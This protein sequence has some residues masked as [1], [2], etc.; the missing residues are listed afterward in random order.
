MWISIITL[1]P[2]MFQALQVGVIGKAIK[3]NRLILSCVNPRDFTTDARHSVDDRPYG[4]GTGMIMMVEPLY[5]ALQA[6]KNAAPTTPTTIYLSPQ[7]QLFNQATALQFKETTS[8]IFIAGRYEGIDERLIEQEVD[9]EW[10]IG[11]YILT[12]GELAAMVMVDAT[13]RLLPGVVGDPASIT[14]DSITTGLLKYPQYTRPE[15]ALNLP[16]PD[17]LLSGN[18]A[19]IQTWRL[20]QS[21]SRTAQ[22]RPDLLEKR[23][24]T[25]E[26][27][28]LLQALQKEKKPN[29]K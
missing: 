28:S 15:L 19:A 1:F 13:V 10:S 26:E 9:Q 20:K 17:V 11:D 3:E 2:E 21:L 8:L 14:Q 25:N 6:A 4:G 24:L 12:G 16:V 27:K 18:H 7:G 23:N 5:L 29:Q 22:R